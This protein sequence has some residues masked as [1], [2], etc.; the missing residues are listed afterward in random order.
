MTFNFFHCFRMAKV[1]RHISSTHRTV[2]GPKCLI[3]SVRKLL[4]PAALCLFLFLTPCISSYILC[5]K[6]TNEVI[7]ICFPLCLY[8]HRMGDGE[9]FG[10]A[11]PFPLSF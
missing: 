5:K 10:W 7:L 2:L 1:S 3:C 4:I 11:L 8:F 6:D 9:Q